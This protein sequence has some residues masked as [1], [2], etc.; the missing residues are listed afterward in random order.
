MSFCP[1][2]RRSGERDPSN[3]FLPELSSSISRRMSSSS[4]SSVP[5]SHV[6]RT[7][8]PLSHMPTSGVALPLPCERGLQ[9]IPLY[10]P[11][12]QRRAAPWYQ[13]HHH[14]CRVHPSPSQKGCGDS[15]LC[16][17]TDLA[18]PWAAAVFLFLEAKVLT[19]E[20][21]HCQA[22]IMDWGRA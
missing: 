2:A 10:M 1:R 5:G 19:L 21:L 14:I 8:F 16:V 11:A 9:L 3:S 12:V 13:L 4:F 20:L 22:Q 15:P 17:R 6:S 18:L 7:R